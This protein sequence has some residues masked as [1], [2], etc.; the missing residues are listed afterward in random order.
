MT[1]KELLKNAEVLKILGDDGVT[2]LNT[3]QTE[4]TANAVTMRELQGRVGGI[5][6]QKKKAQADLAAV[7][8]QLEQLSQGNLS[9][10]EQLKADL[11]KQQSATKALNDSLL[12]QQTQLA[13]EQRQAK[14]ASITKSVNFLDGI[15]DSVQQQTVSMAFDGIEDL[16]DNTATGAIIATLR[17]T[18]AGMIK[19]VGAP[20]GS[21]G[22]GNNG[23][24]GT[25]L[26]GI[27]IP[28]SGMTIDAQ[29]DIVRGIQD[30]SSEDFAKNKTE[31][32]RAAMVEA[33]SRRTL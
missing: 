6:E 5:T 30:M 4:S 8:A 23:G 1:L 33:E 29:D 12:A 28:E 11:A 27:T 19:A 32:H 17:E 7:T 18:H 2:L 21:G 20:A 15:P 26:G 13:A 14:I 10:V 25:D 24:S 16:T 22:H 9:E 3:L 31:L